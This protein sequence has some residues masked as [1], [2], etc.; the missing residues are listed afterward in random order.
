VRGPA[1]VLLRSTCV[2]IAL[3]GGV[4]SSA[5]ANA[6]VIVIN[7]NAAGVG[8]NDPAPAVPVGGNPGTTVG[9]QALDAVQYAAD[10]W[11][12]TLD[13]PVDI[14][15]LVTFEPLTCTATTAALGAARATFILSDFERVGAFPGP[16]L[17][18]T[19]HHSALADKRAGADLV[20]DTYV[21]PDPPY[22]TVSPAPDIRARFNSQIG[23]PGCIPGNGWYYGFDNRAPADHPDL[24]AV[25]LHELAHGLGFSQF[26]DV[27]TGAR[28]A[29]CE[30]CPGLGDV[31]AANL[32]DTT[33]FKYWNDMTDFE[34]QIS[35]TNSR[36]LV[37]DGPA[38]QAAAPSVLI[39]GMPIL[40]IHSPDTV[41]GIYAV[42]TASF[43]PPL[44]TPGETG[45]IV[46][47]I[48]P[49]NTAGP[50][51]SDACSPL[52]NAAD[53]AGQI[54]FVDR[55]TCS[56]LIKAK[57]VQAAGGRAMIVAD[58]IGGAPPAT[59][60]GTDP[61]ITIPAVRITLLDGL[62]LKAHLDEGVN[63]T[64]GVDLTLLAG[65][66]TQGRVYINAPNP[67]VRSSSISHWDPVA[68][69][70]LLMEPA[71]NP[72]LTHSVRPPDD[73]TLPLLRDIGWFPDADNDGFADEVDE[74]DASDMRPALVIFGKDT[75]VKNLLFESGCTMSDDIQLVIA[76]AANHGK[77]VSGVAELVKSW[78][79]AGLIS[80]AEG[81]VITST[82]AG[83][84]AGK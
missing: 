56:F 1:I 70:N 25:V 66:D 20:P 67:V 64:L 32:L 79:K 22:L 10:L 4:T 57:N 42:G 49:A 19:W 7:A 61:A 37:W 27:N 29:L 55:G 43:G 3:L 16:L 80:G 18:N 58:N 75:Q 23:Q 39:P 45:R 26:A 65:A 81:G 82:A 36:R 47:A 35:A 77:F 41:D 72:D 12:A 78:R 31:F 15:A 24:V 54:A 76:R 34:R 8:F 30:G 62:L 73:L 59:M 53:V 84:K 9:Q 83:S 17:P 6:H 46:L 63:G 40:R 60:G 28:P 69:P 11:G 5:D 13:S 68:F 50:S 74:C 48:D 51:T 2:A 14:R 52:T 38:V 44:S 21:D 71:T 33:T